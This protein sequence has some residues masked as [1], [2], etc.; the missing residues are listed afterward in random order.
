MLKTYCDT[1]EILSFKHPQAFSCFHIPLFEFIQSLNAQRGENEIAYL[2]RI[3]GE[4]LDNFRNGALCY[5]CFSEKKPF[6][7]LVLTCVTF[8]GEV[9]SISYFYWSVAVKKCLLLPGK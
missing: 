7:Y 4:N 6:T 2:G 8:S 1:F 5:T 3:F 9:I